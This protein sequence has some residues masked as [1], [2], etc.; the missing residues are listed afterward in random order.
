[1]SESEGNSGL[2]SLAASLH[3]QVEQV[4]RTGEIDRV[5]SADITNLVTSA[6]KLYAAAVEENT[7]DVPVI[8]GTVSTT[9]AIVMACALMR[10]HQLNP[11]DLALWFSHSDPNAKRPA[12]GA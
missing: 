6:V 9:E 7:R 4:F 12:P 1:M 2:S 3:E 10:A 5:P 11:F 8:D